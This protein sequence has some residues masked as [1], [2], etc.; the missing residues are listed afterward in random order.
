MLE[1]YSRASL[2]KT[3]SRH[4]HRNRTDTARDDASIRILAFRVE[5]AFA[6]S[7]ESYLKNA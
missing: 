6:L 3:Q 2:S 5:Q 4:A 7:V 1:G